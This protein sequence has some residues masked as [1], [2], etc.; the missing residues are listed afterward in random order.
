MYL[1]PN[2]WVFHG[3]GSLGDNF[4]AFT[5]SLVNV[6]GGTFGIDFDLFFGGEVNLF[7]GNLFLDGVPAIISCDVNPDGVVD[8]ADIPAFIALIAS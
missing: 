7:G 5:G 8:F 2:V 6:T 1:P 3:G 4:D